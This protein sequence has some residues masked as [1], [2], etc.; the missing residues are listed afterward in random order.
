MANRVNLDISEK[1]DITCK[2]GDTFSLGILLKDSSGT[3]IELS[4]NEYEFLMQVRGAKNP[5]TKSRP[6][7]IGTASK[8]KSAERGGKSLNFTVSVDD[9]GNATFSASSTIMESVPAGKYV[10]DIQQIVGDVSTTILEGRFVV[11]EDISNL[12]L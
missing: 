10:Y 6:L 11:N 1:L 4:T 3:A 9:S 2:K 12:D 8:G 5:R 7:I